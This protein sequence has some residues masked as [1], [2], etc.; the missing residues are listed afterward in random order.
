MLLKT[1]PKPLDPNNLFEGDLLGRKDHVESFARL[2]LSLDTPNTLS[3]NA[4]WGAG[5]T[6]FLKFLEATLINNSCK[7]VFYSAWETDFASDPL[8]AFLGE[9][10]QQLINM[11]GQDDESGQAWK[12]TKIIGNHLIKRSIPLAMRLGTLGLVESETLEEELAKAT[13]DVS[14]DLVDYYTRDKELI[15][16]FKE[17]L[18]TFLKS[19]G[20]E[21]KQIYVFIDE[22]DRCRPTYAIEL[23]ERIKHLLDVP[24]LNF[25]L[26]MDDVQLVHSIRAVYGAEFDSKTYLSRFID[27]KFQLPGVST[28]GFIQSRLE[29]LG[30]SDFLEKR[31][32]ANYISEINDHLSFFS[33]NLKLTLRD[34][35]QILSELNVSIRGAKWDF[36]IQMALL[37]LV[38]RRKNSEAYLNY[39]SPSGTTEN[40]LQYL[41]N[42]IDEAYESSD[43]Y[44]VIQKNVLRSKF[45]RKYRNPLTEDSFVRFEQYASSDNYILNHTANA[46][47]KNLNDTRSGFG[48]ENDP[49]NLS[50][51]IQNIEFSGDFQ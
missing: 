46:I 5:K 40:L 15:D 23:L 47:L 2:L 14:K 7:T 35:E 41:R 27:I 9:I 42:F 30:I 25:V 1:Q 8:L 21:K 43:T 10:N 26:A 18:K 29:S 48:S 31:N 12:K 36:N 32:G 50:S 38:I 22:L 44:F 11:I 28:K 33:K 49:L 45:Q 6:T 37:L 13:G 51:T 16:Q 17:S 19:E 3:I 24:G 39:V 20:T 34:L 4:P